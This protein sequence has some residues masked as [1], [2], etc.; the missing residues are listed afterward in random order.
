M[1]FGFV[2]SDKKPPEY[3]KKNNRLAGNIFANFLQI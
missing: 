1:Q 3:V 2:R